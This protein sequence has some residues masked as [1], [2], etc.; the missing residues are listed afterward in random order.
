MSIIISLKVNDGLVL[1]ADSA[2]TI[3]AKSAEPSGGNLVDNVYDNADKI[4]N[5]HKMLPIGILC[6]GAGAIGSASITTLAKDLRR[7]LMGNDP[8]STSWNI[9]VE[10]YTVAEVA[11]RTRQFMFDELYSPAVDAGAPESTIDFIVVGYS[12]GTAMPEEY[13]MVIDGR[14]CTEPSLLR[15]TE[16]CGLSWR[17]Q[18][19]AISRLVFGHSPSLAIVLEQDMGVPNE[20]IEPAMSLMNAKLQLPLVNDAMPIQDAIRLAEFLVN[21]TIQ[22]SR[23]MP[24]AQVVGGPIEVAVIT[25]HEGFKWVR[26]KH[27]YPQE[28]NPGGQ[29][30]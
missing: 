16:Q 25:K 29:R 7:R 30:R 6:C 4:I 2:T 14:N 22:V 24:G 1:A 15:P 11:Q 26:R 21:L 13:E 28:L 10:N 19:E 27:Y 3:V 5:L 9:D 20:Q 17:G 18:G 8:Q 12:V 23:Y